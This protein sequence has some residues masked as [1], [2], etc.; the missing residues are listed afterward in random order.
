MMDYADKVAIN[1]DRTEEHNVVLKKAASLKL[2]VASAAAGQSNPIANITVAML[3]KMQFVQLDNPFFSISPYASHSKSIL[4]VPGQSEI[5]VMQLFGTIAIQAPGFARQ[6]FDWRAGTTQYDVKL[7]PESIIAGSIESDAIGHEP[8]TVWLASANDR[9]ALKEVVNDTFQFSNLSS[10]P[11]RIQLSRGIQTLT[12]SN[13]SIK[14][15]ERLELR[16]HSD[17]NRQFKLIDRRSS[18]NV[19]SDEIQ[20]TVNG[21][22]QRISSV[23]SYVESIKRHIAEKSPEVANLVTKQY[24]LE[25]IRNR[26]EQLKNNPTEMQYQGQQAV[27][28]QDLISKDQWPVGM[29]Y[30]Y[31]DPS[32]D[33]ADDRY[34]V[35]HVP[36][37]EA[38]S[39][40][41]LLIIKL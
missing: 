25:K 24:L 20:Y 2:N 32:S 4:D 21:E 13:V 35:L 26:L 34:I 10:G 3:P 33:T 8:I 22:A 5:N 9:Y 23:D 11:Y 1:L 19:L 17:V 28:M 37:P 15:G 27:I 30:V 12:T 31:V 7:V 38:E 6:T 29:K 39:L 16:F 18:G 41:Q 14:P 40:E 36:T